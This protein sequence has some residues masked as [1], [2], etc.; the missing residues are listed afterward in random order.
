MSYTY[1]VEEDLSSC[2][3][4]K[5]FWEIEWPESLKI[6]GIHMSTEDGKK[7]SQPPR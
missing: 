3:Q 5:R 6:F 7:K 1:E 2:V 4:K